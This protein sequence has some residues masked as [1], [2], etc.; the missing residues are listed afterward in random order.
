MEFKALQLSYLDELSTAILASTDITLVSEKLSFLLNFY[1][2]INYEMTYDREFWR[3]RKCPTD[4]GFQCVGE[5]NHPPSEHTVA[6][7]LNEENAP[8]LYLSANLMSTFEEIGASK[9]DFLHVAAFKQD[10]NEMLRCAMIGEITHVHRWGSGLTSEIIGQLIN[11]HLNQMPHD[12][13]KSFVFTDAFLS[14]ILKDISA[15]H[16]Q[17]LHSRTLARL[18]FERN[19]GIDAIVYSGVAS[20]ASRNFAIKPRAA[21]RTLQ[22]S[23]SFVIKI[24]QKYK[25]GMYDF[26]VIRN[27]SGVESDGRII[28]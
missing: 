26:E 28:W 10:P 19:P 15:Q 7:R 25:F 13:G 6:G 9:G 21:E 24:I 18:L 17:Y 3:A 8:V 14:S 12:F 1:E 5:L 20:E 4:S 22:I 23:A 11:K 27:A 16:T 2:V